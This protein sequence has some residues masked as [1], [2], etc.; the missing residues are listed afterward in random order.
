L[1]LQ[2]LGFKELSTPTVGGN[3]KPNDLKKGATK[4]ARLLLLL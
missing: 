4:E 3:P 2:G 1:F